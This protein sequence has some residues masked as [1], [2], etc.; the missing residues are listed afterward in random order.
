V[1]IGA[2]AA[3][4]LLLEEL[5]PALDEE[6]DEPEP[7]DDEPEDPELDDFAAGALLDEEPRLS[8]R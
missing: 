1:R 6:L 8:F 7:E 5:L 4:V 2:Y 3:V